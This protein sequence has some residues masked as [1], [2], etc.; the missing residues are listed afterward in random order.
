MKPGAAGYV[1]TE[2]SPSIADRFYATP[3]IV[4]GDLDQAY[5]RVLRATE[6]DARFGTAW[7]LGGTTPTTRAAFSVSKVYFGCLHESEVVRE[8]TSLRVSHLC[9]LKGEVEIAMRLTAATAD[10]TAGSLRTARAGEGTSGP[11]VDAW[12]VAL[13]MPASPI[14]N[15]PEA[16]VAALVAD[17]CAAGCLVLGEPRAFPGDSWSG[18]DG[19]TL[20]QDGVVLA[21]GDVGGLVVSPLECVLDFCAEALTHGFCLRSGQWIS[22]G[23]LT[24]CV[25]LQPGHR[26]AVRHDGNLVLDFD[27][28]N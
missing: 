7:K 1:R 8:P 27:L 23:S 24:P 4:D 21:A 28:Q 16:G 18:P 25:P 20:E 12:C 6:A 9:E 11:F 14:V 2:I 15:L 3:E 19:F 5:R 22:T 13:E 10:S 26:V 17:R